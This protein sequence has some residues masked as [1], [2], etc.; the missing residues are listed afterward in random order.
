MA[1]S[2]PTAVSLFFHLVVVRA[3]TKLSSPYVESVHAVAKQLGELDEQARKEAYELLLTECGGDEKKAAE[4]LKMDGQLF[5]DL[6]K[7]PTFR[8][9]FPWFEEVHLASA[10][11]EQVKYHKHHGA[12]HTLKH[13]VLD[14]EQERLNSM[15]RN[16][17]KRN[18]EAAT[19]LTNAG[20]GEPTSLE[21][22]LIADSN[23][24][25]LSF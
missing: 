8:S 15:L 11:R 25:W 10:K 3:A 4:A 22:L 1:T 2:T 5:V 9:T 14:K 16:P 12:W 13:K 18:S 17:R 23:S 7:L 6:Y 21:Y 20:R 24:Q 19:M